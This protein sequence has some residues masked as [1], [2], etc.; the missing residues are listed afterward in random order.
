MKTITESILSSN[1]VGITVAIEKWWDAMDWP[2][3]KLFAAD[4]NDKTKYIYQGTKLIIDRNFNYE[5]PGWIIFPNIKTLVLSNPKLKTVSR[6]PQD[7]NKVF[8]TGWPNGVIENIP[9]CKKLDI[10]DCCWFNILN[11]GERH[12][13]ELVIE[14]CKKFTTFKNLPKDIDSLVL[15]DC[16]SLTS[17]ADLP[18]SIKDISISDCGITSFEGLPEVING[19]LEITNCEGI[20]NL[21][22]FPKKVKGSVYLAKL[23][24]PFKESEIKGI[25][26][27]NNITCR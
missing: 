19:D 14:N 15:S 10:K 25:C 26:K 16:P 20:T 9:T 5:Y 27:C 4:P 7:V 18:N 1:N 2:E 23:G 3:R 8:I 11:Y 24:R 22:G 13:D 21:N 17:L 12:L 6:W